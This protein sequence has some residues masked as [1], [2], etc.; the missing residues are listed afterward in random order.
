MIC[1]F[2]YERVHQYGKKICRSSKNFV[3]LALTINNRSQKHR[4]FHLETSNYKEVDLFAKPEGAPRLHIELPDVCSPV[5]S[6]TR[7][8]PLKKSILRKLETRRDS[9]FL[10]NEFYKGN[11][12]GE[13]YCRG[14]VL[15]KKTERNS[16]NQLSYAKLH[17]HLYEL[18][19]TPGFEDRYIRLSDLHFS[20]D[21]YFTV[22]QEAEG[23][24][25]EVSHLYLLEW[26]L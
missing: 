8:F 15:R 2:R 25:T 12:T 26:I 23:E 6:S 1:C 11:T 20:N 16:S 21:F 4:A 24:E 19:E 9:Y 5:P 14:S 17:G 13:I 18:E 7:P 10:A 3:N 22:K